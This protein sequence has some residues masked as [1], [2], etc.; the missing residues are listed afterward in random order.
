M[1]GM[2]HC[3]K[4]CGKMQSKKGDSAMYCKTCGVYIEDSA[5]VCVH[6]GSEK[7]QGTAY[8][9]YC[10]GAVRPG[11]PSCL[12]CGR[13]LGVA[14]DPKA[15]SRTAAGLL[16]IFLGAFGAHN[17][18]LGHTGKAMAQLLIT[19]LSLG[20]LAVFSAIWGIAEGL[21]LFAASHPVDA[22]DRLLR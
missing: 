15:K 11:A 12:H 21:H 20:T 1:R 3:G 8:C 6:C 4:K 13:S 18:Y 10:G 19:L 5:A 9:A 2:L 17:F 7:G 14:A 22:D 16:A